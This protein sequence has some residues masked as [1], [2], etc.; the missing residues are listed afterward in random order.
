MASAA[1]GGNQFTPLLVLYRVE[2]GFS[3]TEVYLLLACYVAGIVPTVLMA[4]DLSDRVGRR[5]AFGSAP[6]VAMAG[7]AVLAVGAASVPVLAV[8]RVLSGIGVGLAMAVGTTWLKELSEPP[9]ESDA[10]PGAA[11]RRASVALTAGFLLGAGIAGI[12][13][14]WA[15]W[16][17]RTPYGIHLALT[18]PA[19]LL[20]RRAPET[21]RPAAGG[22][23]S[24]VR[25]RGPGRPGPRFVR[26]ILPTA[27]WVFGAVGVAYALLPNL[28]AASVGHLRIAYSALATVVTL[29]SSVGSQP[30]VRRF[31]H[32]GTTLTL[33]V[34]LA[35][36]SL[37]MALA[38]LTAAR[39]SPWL[40][41]GAAVVLG[42]S[43]GT[44]LVSGLLDIH[45]TT[46]SVD[47]PGTVAAFYCLTYLGFWAPVGMALAASRFS[48][49]VMLTAG[50]VV[51]ALTAAWIVAAGHRP[52]LLGSVRD[53][54]V[55]PG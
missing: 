25:R 10:L 15:P 50:A 37:G 42:V 45:A 38:A 47:L 19:W 52:A 20:V 39:P 23:R 13:A 40:A 55:Q 48:Y 28:V 4:G 53:G 46:A 12:A 24:L 11:A 6:L 8:G 54:T 9:W 44:N 51:A 3:A 16:P 5:R 34:A 26:L 7:S 43:Y 35:L 30:L 1:W 41:L 22:R 36:A 18:L 27:P 31:D 17:T 33:S 2:Q 32:R 49:P 29:G 21:R 14:Q